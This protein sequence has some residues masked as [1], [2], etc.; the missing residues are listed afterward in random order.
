MASPP[1]TELTLRAR[2]IFRLV[3]EDYLRQAERIIVVENNA[4]GQFARLLRAE[5]GCAI[6]AQ[7]L[8]Y[9]GLPFSVEEIV[10]LL[11]EED[12]L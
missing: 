1:I 5:T 3:V 11:R 6:A 12:Q 9:N 4:T 10:A 2:E 7:W 8:K